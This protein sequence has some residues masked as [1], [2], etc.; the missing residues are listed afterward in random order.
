MFTKER[1]SDM[2]DVN[3]KICD[4]I[5]TNWLFDSLSQKMTDL[6]FSF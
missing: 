4:I 2:N 3:R 6:T 5:E 1:R